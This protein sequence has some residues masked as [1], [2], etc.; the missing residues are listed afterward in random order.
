MGA[1]GQIFK[2][3]SG[4]FHSRSYDYAL[5]IGIGIVSLLV[6]AR[7]LIQNRIRRSSLPRQ[8]G[9]PSFEERI[10]VVIMLWQR[11]VTELGYGEKAEGG[12]N[13]MLNNARSLTL[14]LQKEIDVC[15]AKS[16]V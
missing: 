2:N 8:N 4:W 14:K 16:V 7:L 9:Y 11:W 3:V 12:R 13:V 1:C 5:N 10:S 6:A 15:A